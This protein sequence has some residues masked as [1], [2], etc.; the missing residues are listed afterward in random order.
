MAAAKHLAK[1]VWGQTVM[2]GD[3]SLGQRLGAFGVYAAITFL[4]SRGKHVTR[5]SLAKYLRCSP[6]AIKVHLENLVEIGLINIVADDDPRHT[7]YELSNDDFAKA[8][9]LIELH[10]WLDD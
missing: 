8:V 7:L 6:P 3:L 10:G 5:A 4:R 2:A 9:K 1:D